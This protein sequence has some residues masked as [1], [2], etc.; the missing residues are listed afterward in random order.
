MLAGVTF[1]VPF[2]LAVLWE[3]KDLRVTSTQ[4][5]ESGKSVPILGEVARLPSSNA[6]SKQQRVYEEESV[7]S[8]RANLMFSKNIGSMQTF[9]VA[10]SMSGEGKSS[11]ASHLALSL[12]R[13]TGE[14]VLLVDADMRSPDQ[15]HLFGIDLGKGLAAV[16][17]GAVSL[18]SAIDRSLGRSFAYPAG[19]KA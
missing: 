13:A 7:E 5:L 17:E 6:V 11:L 15:H 12:A 16:L 1:I 14:S 19:W 4:V 3:L 18:E 8:V 9:V 2:V 10:S